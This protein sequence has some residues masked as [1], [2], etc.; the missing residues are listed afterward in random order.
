MSRSRARDRSRPSGGASAPT[1]LSTLLGAT[2][3]RALWLAQPDLIV[4]GTGVAQWTDASG[5]GLHAV[6]A[7]G[8]SQPAY[9]AITSGYGYVAGNG[10]Q[11]LIAPSASLACL[12][13]GTGATLVAVIERS[14]TVG[15]YI[16]GSQ[17]SSGI[18]RGLAVS[19]QAAGVRVSVGNGSAEIIAL[20]PTVSAGAWH[21]VIV[22]YAS[23]TDPD[24]SLYRT[25]MITADATANET[26]AP[27]ASASP[28]G[29]GIC[30]GGNSTFGTTTRIRAL[31]VIA[32]EINQAT[33]EQIAAAFTAYWGV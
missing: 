21:D 13:D 2:S 5:N 4:T 18:N 33:R 26:G 22:S 30:W 12:H 3:W 17:T 28:V 29:W 14:G 24:A 16:C 19:N 11:G 10:S 9:T 23:G 31:G 25:S 1:L 6:Q 8:A 32:S 7:A 15:N 20:N 27:N